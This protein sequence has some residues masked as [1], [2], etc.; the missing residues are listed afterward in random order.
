MSKKNSS[1]KTDPSFTNVGDNLKAQNASWDFGGETP[2][3]FPEHVRRSVPLYDEGHKVIA[4]LSDFFVNENSV[5]Y[6]LGCSTGELSMLLA[7]RHK[8]KASTRWVAVDAEEDMISVAKK[9]DSHQ[10]PIEWLCEDINLMSFEKT[11]FIV[12][13]YSIQ[14]ISPRLRQDLFNKIYESLNWGG[15]F[16]MFEKVRGPDARFQD[17][18][19]SLYTEFKLSNNYTPEEIISKNRS[20]KGI[21]EPFSTEGNRDLL[22]RAGFKDVM[23]VM[24]YLC[25]EG[26]LAIK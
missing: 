20:L 22:S 25:F 4:D 11:D 5:C 7:E 23:S 6:D 24:K 15:A 10:N 13:Y 1:L 21:L 17:I 12:A 14:F 8:E 18:L 3:F 9:S 19:T 2:Q 26:F 16:V